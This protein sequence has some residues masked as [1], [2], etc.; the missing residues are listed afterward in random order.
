MAFSTQSFLLQVSIFIVWHLYIYLYFLYQATWERSRGAFKVFPEIGKD[1]H[2]FLKKV[3]EWIQ[4]RKRTSNRDG[5]ATDAIRDAT[6]V[7]PGAG[8]YTVIEMFLLSGKY[9]VILQKYFPYR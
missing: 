5:L 4:Q 8:V 6:E 3:V 9:Y 1:L 2:G 7:W